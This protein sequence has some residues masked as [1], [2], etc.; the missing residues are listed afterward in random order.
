MRPQPRSIFKPLIAAEIEVLKATIEGSLSVT[1]PQAIIRQQLVAAGLIAK[2][3]LLDLVAT[4]K[5]AKKPAK[6]AKGFI[7]TP[8]GLAALLDAVPVDSITACRPT[9]VSPA[10]PSQDR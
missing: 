1:P 6:Q 8:E 3:P 7:V 9:D 5:G 10:P 2:V 4:K